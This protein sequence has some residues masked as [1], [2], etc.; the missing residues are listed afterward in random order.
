MV[1][2]ILLMQFT[3]KLITELALLNCTVVSSFCVGE[4]TIDTDLWSCISVA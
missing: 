3:E 4:V 2:I 1:Y